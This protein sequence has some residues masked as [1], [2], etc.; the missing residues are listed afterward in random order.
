MKTLQS[1][2]VHFT[3]KK[4]QKA[5]SRMYALPWLLTGIRYFLA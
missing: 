1:F 3:I 2:D 5:V 4:R